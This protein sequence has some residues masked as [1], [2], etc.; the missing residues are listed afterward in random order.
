M[1]NPSPQPT[2]VWVTASRLVW[3]GSKDFVRD[4]AEGNMERTRKKETA[5][6]L[7]S[8][9]NAHVLSPIPGL[10][11]YEGAAWKPARSTS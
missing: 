8:G 4:M 1:S 10:S 5:F 2:A 7:I 9:G 3:R 6:E 11:C